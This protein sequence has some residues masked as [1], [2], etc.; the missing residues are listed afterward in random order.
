MQ[1]LTIERGLGGKRKMRF[2]IVLYTTF[3]DLWG[4]IT[5]YTHISSYYRFVCF[6]LL[7]HF[8]T[9]AFLTF[10]LVYMFVFLHGFFGILGAVNE[11]S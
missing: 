7:L 5:G 6:I 11:F 1:T 9:A 8:L 4:L 2:N 3:I 10:H